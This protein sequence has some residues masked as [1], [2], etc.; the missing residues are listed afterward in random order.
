MN[1]RVKIEEGED[2]WDD[3][4]KLVCGMPVEDPWSMWRTESLK[5]LE[6]AWALK[7]ERG[8]RAAMIMAKML[9]IQKKEQALA[10]E[11]RVSEKRLRRLTRRE[12]DLAVGIEKI[13][14]ALESH[15]QNKVSSQPSNTHLSNYRP[16]TETIRPK[17]KTY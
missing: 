16:V 11:E 2:L 7:T 10:D 9:E 14:Q 3:N 17:R 6:S 12:K 15:W 4:L 8:Q 5:A 1:A 13:D